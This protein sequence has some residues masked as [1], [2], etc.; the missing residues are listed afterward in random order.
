[1]SSSANITG[2]LAQLI[3]GTI[4]SQTPSKSVRSLNPVSFS[5]SYYD[6]K[7]KELNNRTTP[8]INATKR[9]IVLKHID[10]T[11]ILI[12][13]A[14]SETTWFEIMRDFLPNYGVSKTTTDAIS[15]TGVGNYPK[16]RIWI[17]PDKLNS[18]NIVPTLSDGEIVNLNRFP[19]CS[20]KDIA[21]SE[22]LVEG[23]LIR[24]DFEN[25][26]LSN[27]A[28][29]LSV[30]NNDKEF[31]RAIFNELEGMASP[32][33]QFAPCNEQG[34]AVSHST[35]DAVAS[36][37]NSLSTGGQEPK[38]TMSPT[39]S[40]VTCGDVSQIGDTGAV[41]GIMPPAAIDG[42]YDS[43]QE[44]FRRGASLGYAT[45]F[46]TINGKMIIKEVAG[47]VQAMMSAASNE[48]VT[49]QVTSGFRTMADQQR[50]Y[51]KYL[52]GTGNL[53]AKAG[54]SNH[55][56]GIAVDFNVSA[57]SGRVFEWMTKNAWRYGFIRTVPR[58]RW[59]WEYWGDWN[60]V[61]KPSWANGWH[62]PKTMFSSVR[63][64]HACGEEPGGGTSPMR[65]SNWWTSKGASQSHT[66]SQTGGRTDSWIGFGNEHLPD[67]FDKEYPGWDRA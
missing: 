2:L 46:V 12:S 56:N 32:E 61:E 8:Q 5:T 18:D 3:N 15:A 45:E 26:L 21:M 38:A 49:M 39:P 58:E 6:S 55:Q 60:G 51:D 63:R 44:L 42:V 17:L 57:N 14:G 29:V 67:K 59:H 27:D 16:Y 54:Y 53:A 48:G 23:A 1:M 34:V 64:V 31:G 33:G 47:Y 9:A 10:N 62:S 37:G 4:E 28:Y 7:A 30:M 36:G 43:R 13:T 35:G 65:Q 11:P 24:I 52:A 25:R 19:L 50:L 22:E 40:I 41:A 66:D 20:V